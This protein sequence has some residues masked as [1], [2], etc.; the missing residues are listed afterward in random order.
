[1]KP[2][3]VVLDGALMNSGDLSW[4]DLLALGNCALYERTPP[5]LVLDRC[6]DAE[7][8]I[9]NKVV[10]SREIIDQLP[11]LKYIGITA[12]GTNNV[13]LK[14]AAERGIV[15]TNIPAY[16]TPSVA[17]HTIALLLEATNQVGRHAAAVNGGEWESS[18]DFC[19]WKTPLIELNQMTLGLIGYGE[20]GEQVAKIAKSFGMKIL[21]YTR[22]K[23]DPALEYVDLKSLLQKSDVVSLHCPYTTETRHII[24]GETL[25]WMKPTA[26]LINT[27]R[28]PLIDETALAKALQEKR[29]FGAALDVLEHEPPSS[30][31]PLLRLENCWIT[32]HIAWSTV[33]ARRRLFSTV[34]DNVKAFL[35]GSPQ[36]RV[37]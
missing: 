6:R 13:D 25:S 34:V 14:A 3:I 20:I 7:I 36:N 26:I 10:L 37:T 12:T 2:N 8:V 1:M 9:S 16:S 28:G 17:Q 24:N 30:N 4:D 27:S 33:A 35:A 18:P 29:I 23:K 11:R 5:H 31:C 21:V 19:F 32:P 22:T 15:A